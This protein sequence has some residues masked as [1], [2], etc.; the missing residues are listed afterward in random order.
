VKDELP[1]RCGGVDA[2]GERAEADATLVEVRERRD[3]VLQ[4]APQP[5]E[6][7]DDERVTGAEMVERLG[8]ARP[9]TLRT[10]SGVAEDAVAAG[11]C[12]RVELEVEGLFPGRNARVAS[13]HKASVS[14]IAAPYNKWDDDSR[15]SCEMPTYA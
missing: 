12:K 3:E 15:T 6:P 4:R 2:L 8:E 11:R 5:V 7:P 13:K 1:T 14:K 9:V 10:G